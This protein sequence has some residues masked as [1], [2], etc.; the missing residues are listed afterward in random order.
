MRPA[1][2]DL[3]ISRLRTAVLAHDCSGRCDVLTSLLKSDFLDRY[4]SASL[5]SSA[6]YRSSISS[7]A[8]IHR[9]I[10]SSSLHTHTTCT[11]QHVDYTISKENPNSDTRLVDDLDPVN[12]TCFKFH[13]FHNKYAQNLTYTNIKFKKILRLSPRPHRGRAHFTRAS[14]SRPPYL[15]KHYLSPRTLYRMK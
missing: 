4:K 3:R 14:S 1:D 5:K 6:S 9:R 12:R 15:C 7:R 11:Q 2:M 8:P 10:S 13:T